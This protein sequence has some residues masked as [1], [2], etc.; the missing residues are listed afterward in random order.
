[1]LNFLNSPP[2][3]T[4]Y[5]CSVE[6]RVGAKC[7]VQVPRCGVLC[8]DNCHDLP[9]PWHH[10]HHHHL[11]Q[12][13]DTLQPIKL[14]FS[15]IWQLGF[16]QNSWRSNI[17]HLSFVTGETSKSDWNQR[18]STKPVNHGHYLFK[19]KSHDNVDVIS[20][21]PQYI[22]LCCPSW[23]TIINTFYIWNV[24]WRNFIT[25]NLDI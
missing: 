4:K 19:G 5:S 21:L 7:P 3:L 17:Y 16:P 20:W 6:L 23:N 22:I 9:H 15:N 25:I 12:G 10:T 1:M 13:A 18:I 2:V 24:L 14:I 11:C 8:S